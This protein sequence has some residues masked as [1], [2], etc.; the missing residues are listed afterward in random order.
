MQEK[1]KIGRAVQR[2]FKNYKKAGDL[3]FYGQKY[4]N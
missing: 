1:Y 3:Y 2:D 4:N